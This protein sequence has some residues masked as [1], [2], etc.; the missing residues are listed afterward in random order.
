MHLLVTVIQTT[1]LKLVRCRDAQL[2]GSQPR[3]K[4]QNGA[5]EFNCSEH[6]RFQ[7]VL[8]WNG[9]EQLLNMN[10]LKVAARRIS[11]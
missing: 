2:Q 1:Q 11:V 9:S 7:T 3:K 4:E 6:V 10:L 5:A 8:L